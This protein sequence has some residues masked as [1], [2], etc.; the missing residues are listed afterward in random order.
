MDDFRW[1]PALKVW[2]LSMEKKRKLTSD[3]SNPKPF[4]SPN[5]FY[6]AHAARDLRASKSQLNFPNPAPSS[7]VVGAASAA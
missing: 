1:V 6:F 7:Q 5:F 4:N 2:L 3:F